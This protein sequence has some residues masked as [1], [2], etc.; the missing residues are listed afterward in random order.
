MEL[1]LKV[2]AV[3]AQL[4]VVFGEQVSASHMPDDILREVKQ[5]YDAAK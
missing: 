3:I 1:R 5:R 2:W 4:V